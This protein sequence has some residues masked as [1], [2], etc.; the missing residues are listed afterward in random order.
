MTDKTK[1][2]AKRNYTAVAAILSTITSI[3][4]KSPAAKPLLFQGVSTLSMIDQA[5]MSPHRQAALNAVE[6]KAKQLDC[7][8][9]DVITTFVSE[10][11]MASNGHEQTT[12]RGD[13]QPRAARQNA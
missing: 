13:H 10:Q 3:D 5:E 4:P 6:T 9:D 11:K 8:D 2:G 12:G 1:T 7:L